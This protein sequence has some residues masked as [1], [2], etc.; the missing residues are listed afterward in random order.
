M[1]VT[2]IWTVRSRLDHL[3]DYVV[4]TDKT[5]NPQY[6]DLHDVLKYAADDAKT[7]QK[8]FVTGLNCQPETAYA[9]MSNSLKLSDKQ[10]RV[11][12][13]HGYQAFAE[14]EVTASAAHEIGVKLAQELW[15]DRFQVLI[16][17]HLNTGKFHN[18]FV[19]CSTSFIDGKRF[20]AC[21]QSYAQMRKVSDRLCHEYELSVIEKPKFG[22]TKHYAEIV[23]ERDSRPTWRG[24]LKADVDEAVSQSMTES[25]FIANLKKRGYEVKLGKYISVRPA[26]KEQFS[27]LPTKLGDEYSR[28][29]IIK[30]M[31]TQGRPKLPESKPK[32]R[33]VTAKFKGNL[34]T[35]KKLTGFRA[36]YVHYL[37]LLGK[38]PKNKPRL[39][40][41]IHFLYREDL[42]KIDKISKE[43]TLLCRHQIDTSEQL[44]SYKGK[45][46]EELDMLTDQRQE[47][48]NKIRRPK[49]TATVTEVKEQ[50]SLLSTRM[51]EVRKEVVLCDD[52][53]ARTQQIKDKTEKVR[54]E[55]ILNQ[56]RKEKNRYDQFR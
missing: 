9:A 46:T 43:I 32:P 6:G 36:L 28:D 38:I 52:I 35:A 20:H 11:L 53:A 18:H 22:R 2:K 39:L 21:K 41:K 42:L 33:I 34:K 47:L 48:R 55:Q 14:G 8:Y 49:D 24:L 44:F 4:N 51:G 5:E 45:L 37:Y 16:A 31:R 10:L 17:T 56:D 23:A 54:Q 40:S 15:G 13:Y 25:Q 1:A 29:N 7:E 50:I 3:V 30:R 19:L 12:A 26:G 27:R